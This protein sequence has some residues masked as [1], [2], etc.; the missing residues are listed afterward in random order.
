M[1]FVFRPILSIFVAAALAVLVSLG[2]WQLQRLE[3]KREL[4]ARAE[5]RIDD[6]P[7]SFDAAIA[8]AAAGEDMEYA[9]VR[10]EGMFAHDLAAEVY[11]IHDSQP[12]VFVFTPLDAAAEGGR[13]RFV[14]VNRGFVPRDLRGTGGPTG[15]DVR[16]QIAV[17]GLLRKAETPSGLANVFLAK[18]QPERNLWFLRDPV[19][20]AARHGIET[21]PWYID[22]FGRENPAPWPKGGTTR[23]DFPNRHLEYALTW[24]G[25]AAALLAVYAAFTLR[26]SD[27]G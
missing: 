24:F 11:G 13:G 15:G 3:W 8:R 22:S 14:Y 1:R 25:L 7:I 23:L 4:I 17:E 5:A 2:V 9:P 6:A 20:L 16:R 26:R 18:D 12:G 27:E 19:R 10:L 21:V